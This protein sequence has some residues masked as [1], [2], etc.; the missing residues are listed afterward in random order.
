MK[1]RALLPLTVV[2][3]A[4]TPAGFS[5]TGP[6]KVIPTSGESKAL[7]RA[8][9]KPA[10]GEHGSIELWKW[11]NFL[12]LAGV[13]GYYARKFGGPY[14]DERSRRIRKD[15]IEAEDTRNDA[16]ARAAAVEKRLANLEAAVS[17]LRNEAQAEREAETERI[18]Q[19][20]AAEIAKIEAHALQEIAS[21]G[22]S[23]KSELKR[24]SAQLAIGLAEEKIRS[25]MDP[26]TQDVLV[27][28]FTKGLEPSRC[29]AEAN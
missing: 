3:L 5:Q 19:Q 27:Q 13:L 14:F 9:E 12:V 23:A 10:E 11:A 15:I 28:A 2:V 26:G 4:M 7:E 22:K 18:R 29:R 17:A 24:Y 21:A 6:A 1:R 16:E 20:T 25:R 8:A